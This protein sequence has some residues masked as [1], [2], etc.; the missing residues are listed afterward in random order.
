MILGLHRFISSNEAFGFL[1]S[2]ISQLL[3]SKREFEFYAQS[4]EDE[5]I[6]RYCPEQYGSY[7][8]VGSGRPISGSNSYFFTKKVGMAYL[9]TQSREMKG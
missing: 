1:S 4:K 9:L 6:S 8:D 3:A 2:L 7:V 5:I